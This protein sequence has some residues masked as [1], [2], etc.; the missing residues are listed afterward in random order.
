MGKSLL[1]RFDRDVPAVSGLTH[2]AIQ[3][4][5]NDIDRS[6]SAPGGVAVTADDL[7]AGYRQLIARARAHRIKVMRATILPF[8]RE[9]AYG[10]YSLE[11]VAIRQRVNNWIRT[12]DSYDGVID[13]DRIV[14]D[15]G[16]S[17]RLLPAFD[18]GDHVYPNCIGHRA[19]A[20]TVNPALFD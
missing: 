5:I 9:T 7:I 4:G 12:S 10:Y 13:F 1:A 14:R 8:E 19:M 20:T 11:H 17:G 2:L 18:N 15:P 3:G 16:R 6:N